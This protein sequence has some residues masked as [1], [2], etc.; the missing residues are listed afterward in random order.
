MLYNQ[1]T[2]FSLSSQEL[3]EELQSQPVLPN[4]QEI[5]LGAPSQSDR[6]AC[7]Y[8][9]S[10]SAFFVRGEG[11]GKDPVPCLATTVQ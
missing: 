10:E 3:R 2:E 4:R 9:G 7:C 5:V 1:G 6:R 8:V 11:K